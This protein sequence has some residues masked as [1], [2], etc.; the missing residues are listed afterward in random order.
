MRGK[1]LLSL[2]PAAAV[3]FAAA[4]TPAPAAAIQTAASST[5]VVD[6]DSAR[7]LYESNADEER[8]IASI[9]K[10]MTA[11]VAIED[12]SAEELEQVCTVS[13]YAASV[14]GSSLYLKAGDKIKLISALYGCMLCSG[15]DCAI[16]VAEAV[17][18]SEEAF[19]E[20]M[21]EKAAEL[22]ME[23]THFCSCNGLADEDN[24]STARDMAVLGAYAIQNDRF[25]EIC[26]A[27]SLTT[28]DGY[29]V[30]NHNKLLTYDE[31]C[32]GIKTGFT[33]KAGR[34]LVSCARDPDSGERVVCV[35]LNDPCDFDDHM[36]AY[37]WAF[38]TF[39][40]HTLTTAGEPVTELAFAQSGQTLALVAEE[41]LVF[42]FREG[43]EA[44]LTCELCCP[45]E[46]AADGWAGD[47]S[48]YLDGEK[49]ASTRL[50]CEEGAA[51]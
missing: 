42:P 27:R 21:N 10:I 26:G 33:K 3:L 40:P 17:A 1:R 37:D 51:A 16:V 7:V 31:R 48:F 24:Y 39:E 29:W 25:A 46:A 20:K 43:E 28:E 50:Y 35:T 22:G 30:K 19:A 45:G 11:L 18:G 49:I 12:S 38:E 44:G 32:I 34:T 36:A 9:T 15:N 4:L 47:L 5:C 13:K 8:P 2:L 14:G 6:V 23:H 41:T